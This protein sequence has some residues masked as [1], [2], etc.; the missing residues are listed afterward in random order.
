[1]VDPDYLAPP[2]DKHTEAM[3]V[4]QEEDDEVL[5]F[6]ENWTEGFDGGKY[7]EDH[8]TGYA[9]VSLAGLTRPVDRATPSW[10]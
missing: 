7:G 4:V 6:N 9:W 2:D 1:M 8:L 3:V 5:V 10:R